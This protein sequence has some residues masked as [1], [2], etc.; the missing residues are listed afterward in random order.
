MNLQCIH[1]LHKLEK[2]HK[3]H[4]FAKFFIQLNFDKYVQNSM[5]LTMKEKNGLIDL[6]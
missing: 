6:F 1:Q 4:L 5:L 2:S 3:N